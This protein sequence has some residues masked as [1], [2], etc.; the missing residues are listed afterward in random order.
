VAGLDDPLLR[1][2]RIGVQMIGDD[3]ANT[4]PAH[5]LSRRGIIGNVVGFMVY[6]D[7]AAA[8]PAAAIVRAVA[9][10]ELD[11]ALVWGP[12]AGYFAAREVPPLVVTP[13]TAARSDLPFEFDIAMGVRKTD[14]ARRDVLDR[15][16]ERRKADVDRILAEYHVPRVDRAPAGTGP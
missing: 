3:F 4:P 6:G 2:L 5:A 14:R 8:N 9:S 16:L 10:G 15:V 1:A 11:L 12:L 13:L 7:Y